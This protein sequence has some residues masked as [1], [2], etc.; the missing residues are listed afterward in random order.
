M[1][2]NRSIGSIQDLGGGKYRL[3]VSEKFDQY[4]RRNQFSRVIHATS[5]RAAEEALIELI[6]EKKKLADLRIKEA[7]KTLGAL[8]AEFKQ[9]YM[10]TLRPSTQQFY[11]NL[12]NT[13]IIGYEKSKLKTFS[14]KMVYG[15]INEC[16][17]K[18]RTQKGIYGL[19]RTMFHNAVGWGYMPEN[20]CEKVQT[21]KY[22]S[23]EKIILTEDQLSITMDLVQKEDLIYQA[24]FY[25]AVMCGM[26]RGE[27]MGLRWD[28]VD[29]ERRTV[30]IKQAA[31]QSK[32][33]T[34][35]GDTK[36]KKSMRKLTLPET[37]LPIL[38]LL[39]GQ[40]DEGKLRLAEKWVDTPFMF[41]GWNG[42]PLGVNA[43][44][45][46]WKRFCLSHPELPPTTFHAL[47][48]TA[49]TLLIKNNVPISTVS[50]ILGHA[51]MATTVNIYTHVIEDA[52][53]EALGILESALTKKKLPDTAAEM[54]AF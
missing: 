37:L 14:P 15:I 46:W 1:S 8:Y 48:H 20:P 19:L 29:L 4:G 45:R 12:W 34:Y 42:E 23:D 54:S 53:K 18:P 27:I 24:F 47:R 28:D 11:E 2:N 7:P 25:F 41:K 38:R 43:P 36:N 51:Q 31:G 40:Q 33:G 35:Y 26:R 39:R 6:N 5:E 22:K 49:A 10:S 44:T 32:K 3:R 52:K 13:H 17:D 50:G 30:S 21:P 16:K 9:N